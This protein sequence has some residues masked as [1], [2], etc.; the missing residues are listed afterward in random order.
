MIEDLVSWIKLQAGNR[1]KSTILIELDDTIACMVNVLLAK[2]TGLAVHALI[3]CDKFHWHISRNFC[4]SLNIDYTRAT[5]QVKYLCD[6]MPEIDEFQDK[7]IKYID[8]ENFAVELQK[9]NRIGY[10]AETTNS[11]V[12]SNITRDDYLFIRNYH[13]LNPCDIMP[14]AN[15]SMSMVNDIFNELVPVK[16][17]EIKE[18]CKI[19]A[20]PN[21]EME[22]LFNTNERNKI[23]DSEDDPTKNHSWYTY[24]A[25]QK[26][27]IAKV[28]QIEKATRYKENNS[29]L[30]YTL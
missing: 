28:H 15:L 30:A 18:I 25:S 9:I 13:K 10:I 29:I 16:S 3:D 22:W 8:N 14:F 19:A 27:L 5:Y 23:I 2:K 11:L 17:R 1:N 20:K 7:R 12:P 26:A 24:T 6:L 21:P 4:E